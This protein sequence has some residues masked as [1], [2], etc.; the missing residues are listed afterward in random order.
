MSTC[1]VSAAVC[2]RWHVAVLAVLFACSLMSFFLPR[3]QVSFHMCHFGSVYRR[4]LYVGSPFCRRS[5]VMILSCYLSFVDSCARVPV[6]SS[7]ARVPV[8]PWIAGV[9]VCPC[10]RGFL[11][12]PCA[13]VPVDSSCARVPV[14]PCARGFLVCP[15]ARVPGGP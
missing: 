12:C 10:V 8:C 3:S 15:C 9:P 1:G 5:V 13:R 11:V 2:C 6:D 7:C 4:F 14:C